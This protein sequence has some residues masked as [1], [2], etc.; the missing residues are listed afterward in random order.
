MSVAKFV[1]GFNGLPCGCGAVFEKLL[2][3]WAL[4]FPESDLALLEYEAKIKKHKT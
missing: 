2:I 4:T 1:F 3:A